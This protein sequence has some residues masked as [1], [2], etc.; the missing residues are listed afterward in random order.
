MAYQQPEAEILSVGVHGDAVRTV[1]RTSK[2]PSP[3]IAPASIKI[4]APGGDVEFE[5]HKLVRVEGNEITFETY[6][7]YNTLPTVGNTYAI[8][9]WWAPYQLELAQDV[10]REWNK[11]LFVPRN[12][13]AF[14]DKGVTRMRRLEE[15]EEVPRGAELVPEGWE[16]EH[17]ALCWQT[18]SCAESDDHEG[19]TDGNYWL[20]AVCYQRY[21]GSG[22]GKKLG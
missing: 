21:I 14:H 11:Q 3:P 18:I 2:V 1:L 22:F 12:G 16:H 6:G 13:I 4:P 7:P 20:C 19:Y 8:G 10:T 17:C 9:F 15:G 5:F